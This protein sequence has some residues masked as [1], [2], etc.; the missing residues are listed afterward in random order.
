MKDFYED[1]LFEEEVEEIEE[2]LE[3][4]GISGLEEGFMLGEKRAYFKRG[5]EN[6]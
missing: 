2:Q 3:S 4:D 1:E 5:A 6:E